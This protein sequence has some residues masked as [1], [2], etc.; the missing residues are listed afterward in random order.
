MDCP[1][2]G[3]PA[4]CFVRISQRP[5]LRASSPRWSASEWCVV[6]YIAVTFLLPWRDVNTG[7]GRVPAERLHTTPSFILPG[8]PDCN[9]F[10]NGTVVG[11]DGTVGMATYCGMNR[12]AIE[13]RWGRDFSHPFRP[14]LGPTQPP[15]QWVPVKSAGAWRW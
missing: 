1:G 12:P 10:S 2:R 4:C 3:I 13:S 15:I 7:R 6:V 8:D 9:D 14:T 5:W 11:R